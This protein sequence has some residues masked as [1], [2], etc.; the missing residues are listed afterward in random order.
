V[1][2]IMS[3]P[4][5]IARWLLRMAIAI[6]WMYQG[7]WHK[8]IEIDGPH[9]RMMK[10]VLGEK[11]GV[12]ACVS[13]GILEG[14]LSGAVL[15]SWRPFLVAWMQIGLLAAMNTASMLTAFNQISD[16]AGMLTMNFVFAVAIWTN[17]WFARHVHGNSNV[18]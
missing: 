14:L 15:M 9:R 4:P 13:L 10:E 2:G 6:V 7:I 12:A 5:V 16:P 1:I 18:G 8:V 17:A 11:I 3:P